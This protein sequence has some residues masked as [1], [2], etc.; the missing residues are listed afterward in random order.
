MIRTL[1]IQPAKLLSASRK[2]VELVHL[3]IHAWRLNIDNKITGSSSKHLAPLTDFPPG[4]YNFTFD[5]S[6]RS[7]QKTPQMG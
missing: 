1:N 3:P 4:S 2:K 6:D 7:D 5:A